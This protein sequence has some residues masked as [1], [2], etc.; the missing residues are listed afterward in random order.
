MFSASPTRLLAALALLGAGLTVGAGPGAATVVDPYPFNDESLTL[1]KVPPYPA[2]LISAGGRGVFDSLTL[3]GIVSQDYGLTTDDPT[4]FTDKLRHTWAHDEPYGDTGGQLNA[5]PTRL[6]NAVSL[7]VGDLDGNGTATDPKVDAAYLVRGIAGGDDH[8][9]VMGS[10]GQGFP[11]LADKAITGGAL[12]LAMTE[13]TPTVPAL[14]FVRY[15]TS[16][17]AYRFNS[18]V[19]GKLSEVT[20]QTGNVIGAGSELF[21]IYHRPSWLNFDEDQSFT[22][23]TRAGALAVAYESPGGLIELN[24]QLL[25]PV[26]YA[27]SVTMFPVSGFLPVVHSLGWSDHAWQSGQVRYDWAE[28]TTGGGIGGIGSVDGYSLVIAGRT[29]N[30]NRIAVDRALGSTVASSDVDGSG[31]LVGPCGDD[32]A[33][34]IDVDV[35]GP[36]TVVGC[37]SVDHVAGAN[38]RLVESLWRGPAGG[39]WS[40]KVAS[41]EVAGAEALRQPDVRVVLSCQWLHKTDPAKSCSDSA[42]FLTD[43]QQAG[44][45]A[46]V[47]TVAAGTNGSS[48]ATTYQTS[49]AYL[50]V[51]TST[52]NTHGLFWWSRVSGDPVPVNSVFPLLSA[53]LPAVDT[54]LRAEVPDDPV[55]NPPEHVTSKPIPV[56]FLPAPP[57]V[58][59]AGQQGDAPEFAA[60]ARSTNGSTTSTSSSLSATLGVEIED[61]TGA[62]G[63][64]F[65][66]TLANEVS[67]EKTVERTVQTA[68]AFRG[69]EDD[70]VVVYRRVP[71]TRWNGTITESSTGIGV[72]QPTSVDLTDGNVVTTATNVGALAAQ[73]P[74]LYGPGGELEPVLDRVFSNTVGDPGSYPQDTAD[75]AA[76]DALCDGSVSPTGPRDLPDL[77]AFVPENPYQSPPSSPPGPDVIMS[78]VH[79]VV[80]GS[81][82]SE[83]ALFTMEDAFTDSR[84]QTS[85]FEVSAQ[86]KA[87]YFTV[88]AS[89]GQSVGHGWSTTLATGVD[90]ASYVG[91]IPSD[92]PALATETYSWRSFL[93]QVT[94][95]ATTGEPVT[96]WVLHYATK[97]YHGSGGMRPLAPVVATG[98]VESQGTDPAGTVLRWKQATGTVETYAWKVEAIGKHDT[99]TG[100]ISY[101][102]PKESNDTN[103]VAHVVPV[104]SALLPGQLYRWKVDATD[105]FGNTVSSD[106]EYFVTNDD[107]SSAE[108]PTAVA[109]RVNTVEDKA[110]AIDA[111]ANDQNPAGGAVTLS[112]ASPPLRGKVSL[113]DG[114]FRY[115]PTRDACGLDAFDYTVTDRNG[116]SSTA[117]DIVKV[118]CVN[119][120]PVAVNDRVRMP[121]GEHTLRLL[122]PGPLGNDL[123]AEHEDLVAKLL[124]KPKIGRVKLGPSGALLLRLPTD[125]ALKGS[126]KLRY[127]ACDPEGACSIGVITVVLR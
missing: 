55:N 3:N 65:E 4:V 28:P 56:A 115:E 37:A 78:D 53:P 104:P 96:A 89:Y 127:R 73:Y 18:G 106:W 99:R 101:A 51:K 57:E 46:L 8:L 64:S 6:V 123:D 113:K 82:N 43:A 109:D 10:Q 77:S 63:A 11:L 60:V 35:S 86:A 29:D 38:D 114:T 110:V 25:A 12:S 97:D 14:L 54:L 58:A 17:K 27:D 5:D 124:R 13:K 102:T 21:D 1:F 47:T 31:P 98:P 2:S 81:G 32:E 23:E 68:Q 34:D 69:L 87:S 111:A 90:F 75:D 71:I 94:T 121:R 41:Q 15:P 88:G 125:T 95:Q 126:L 84:V 103:P 9:Y 100:E 116:R 61:V 105:F 39:G 66:A 119:D 26:G 44:N 120:A 85:S 91:H 16:L 40:H 74:E 7:A 76:V 50:D 30:D 112:L 19:T 93:C 79:Q 22:A 36:S 108:G 33:V 117:T 80:T 59:G 48:L 118:D 122:A 24:A 70:N 67:D 20:V 42:N 107:G 83:G 52:T 72:G 45:A 49:A 92:N 62:Y